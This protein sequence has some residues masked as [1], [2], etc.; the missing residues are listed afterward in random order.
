M[1]SG[2]VYRRIPPYYVGSKGQ[3]SYKAFRVREEDNGG[4]SV[5]VDLKTAM[6]NLKELRSQKSEFSGFVLAAL[7]VSRIRTET[8]AWVRTPNK[9]GAS[10][11]RIENCSS[12][13]TQ[14]ALAAI[15]RILPECPES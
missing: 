1:T 10:H 14:Q 5:D 6:A 11:T 13:D 9:V 15:A 3:I 12:I 4:L 2:E 8:P 7:D